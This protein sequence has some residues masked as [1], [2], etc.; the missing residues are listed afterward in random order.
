MGS[1]YSKIKELLGQ[2]QR[3][4]I[5]LILLRG[6]LYFTGISL[7]YFNVF[8][9]LDAL[10]E[11][12]PVLRYFSLCLYLLVFAGAI[13]AFLVRPFLEKISEDET[14]LFLQRENKLL[15]DDIINFLQ[16][17]RKFETG[18]LKEASSGI[19]EEY[20]KRSLKKIKPEVFSKVKIFPKLKKETVLFSGVVLLFILLYIFPPYLM[21]YSMLRLFDPSLDTASISGFKAL[22]GLPEIGDLK[23]KVYYPSYTGLGVKVIEEGGNAVVLKNSRLEISGTANKPFAAAFATGTE[24]GRGFNL[25]FNLSD[26]L[27]PAL[28]LVIKEDIEYRVGLTDRQGQTNIERAAHSIKV[29]LDEKPQVNMLLPNEELIATPD[30]VIKVIYEYVDDFGVTSVNLVYEKEGKA[31][32]ISLTKNGKPKLHETGEFDFELAGTG[33]TFGDELSLYLE[34]YDNDTIDGPKRG[35][36]QKVKIRLP[37]LQEYLKE[38]N[39]VE[40]EAFDDLLKSADSFKNRQEDFLQQVEKMKKAGDPDLARMLADLDGLQNDLAKLAERLMATARRV[41]EEALNSANMSRLDMGKIAKLMKELEAAIASGDKEAAK[42]LAQELSEAMSEMM[43]SLKN[44]LDSSALGRKNKVMKKA[45]ELGQNVK[46][47]LKEEKEIYERTA[48]AASEGLKELLAGQEKLIEELV[49][50]QQEAVNISAQTL[51]LAADRKFGEYENV[52]SSLGLRELLPVTG[53]LL[54]DFK[55]RKFS[56]AVPELNMVIGFTAGTIKYCEALEKEADARLAELR[57]KTGTEEALKIKISA[58]AV[59]TA[60]ALNL[61]NVNVL[62]KEIVDILQK[63]SEGNNSVSKPVLDP[64]KKKQNE[65][66]DKLSV[67]KDKIA[68]AGKEDFPSAV[69]REDIS[70]AEEAMKNAASELGAGVD[71]EAISQEQEAI[72]HLENIG[73]N[74]EQLQQ[75]GGGAPGGVFIQGGGTKGGR[76]RVNTGKQKLPQKK[77]YKPPK[78]FRE[79]I[80]DSMKEKLPQK[81]KE[82]IE[83]Y[84]KKLLR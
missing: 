5:I 77:E 76:S 27:K 11:F 17:A 40:A 54:K 63:A 26:S 22:T 82:L 48:K 69:F 84:Y 6:G 45:G 42:R 49:K 61:K 59:I 79:D 81:Y 38:E 13:F 73:N 25:P 10:I 28:N 7:L 23:V 37:S 56:T 21:R 67:F 19:T 46:D 72:S 8:C 65:L 34:A 20:L 12:S 68:A 53:K 41:P 58:K 43:A 57:K 33:Y 29:I 74:M 18:E 9:F 32:R 3:K 60:I 47:M 71:Y 52:M 39:P 55:E 35:V 44:M 31:K 36:S 15:K 83:E 70:G 75:G 78:E 50:K 30:A 66:K 62:E 1:Y 2:T 14:A 16:L 80:M 51:S 24:G 64:L 4:A